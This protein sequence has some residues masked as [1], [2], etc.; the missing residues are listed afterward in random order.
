MKKTILFALITFVLTSKVY[1]DQ[2]PST[3]VSVTSEQQQGTQSEATAISSLDPYESFNRSMFDFNMAFHDAIGRPL[4][5]AYREIPQ[6]AR[7]GVENFLNNLKEPLSALNSFLQGNIEDGLGGIMRFALN[8]TLGLF[9]IL[10]IA[11][12]AGLPSKNEDFGQTLYVWGVW[13]NANYLV[14]PLLGPTT[15]RN[16]F[17]DVTE[18]VTDPTQVYDAA[19]FETEERFAIFA[20]SGFVE[21]T[22]IAPLLDDLQNQPDPY[23]FSRESYIQYRIGQIYNG[24]PPTPDLDDFDID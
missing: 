6:P 16:L 21:Y 2:N 11:T 19:D 13:D 12:E 18:S 15:T 8:S 20:T 24:K 14:L 23:Y 17:G 4:A 5:N 1:A 9:G 7:T 3:E 22:K 10:D